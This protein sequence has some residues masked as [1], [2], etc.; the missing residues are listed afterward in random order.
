MFLFTFRIC[1]RENIGWNIDIAIEKISKHNH[2]HDSYGILELQIDIRYIMEKY[3]LQTANYRI[4]ISSFVKLKILNLYHGL[5]GDDKIQ[6]DQSP[7]SSSSDQCELDRDRIIQYICI[8]DEALERVEMLLKTDSLPRFY[9]TDE[10]LTM[11]N[12]Q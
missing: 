5:Y 7:I 9:Q 10:Y 1:E 6:Q 2:D 4:N 11:V 3:I 8:F 12:P